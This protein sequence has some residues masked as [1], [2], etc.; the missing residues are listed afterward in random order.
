MN[1]IQ[2]Q[3]D[4]SCIVWEYCVLIK[5]A[6]VCA[7][8]LVPVSIQHINQFWQFFFSSNGKTFDR[9][10]EYASWT[11]T[12]KV[13]NEIFCVRWEIAPKKYFAHKNNRPATDGAVQ[14]PAERVEDFQNLLMHKKYDEQ[15]KCKKIRY[16]NFYGE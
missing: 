14:L 4:C 10:T 7:F 16:L 8:D 1:P 11:E 5:R 2:L 3:F 9:T 6:I 12:T 13:S 15:N